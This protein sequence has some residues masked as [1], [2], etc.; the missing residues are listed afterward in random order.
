MFADLPGTDTVLF[1]GLDNR[2][3]GL[4]DTWRLNTAAEAWTRVRGPRPPR[5]IGGMAFDSA[6]GL[7][8]LYLGSTTTFE[9]IAQTWLFDPVTDSWEQASG[10]GA[11]AGL[12]G[13]SV[14]YDARS[15]RIVLFGGLDV[16]T[17]ELRDETWI[18]D[19]EADLW[20]VVETTPRPAGR[21]FAAT[22]YDTGSDA[23]ILFGGDTFEGPLDDTWSFDTDTQTWTEIT[24][25]PRPP[26]RAYS[27]AASVTDG[28]VVLFGGVNELPGQ[29]AVYGDTWILDTATQTWTEV[30]QSRSPGPRGF[31]AMTGDAGGGVVVMFGGGRTRE[32]VGDQTWTFD[33]TSRT[34]AR[35]C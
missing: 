32:R 9:P 26:A 20:S 30:T 31:H 21:N 18:Y 16:A 12:I 33:V 1:G 34:W 10:E 24:T 27:G 17:F 35:V 23:I 11:P 22:A 29:E 7:A 5:A 3:H 13:P 4:R 14:A 25:D 15:H 8:V 19:V 2:F 28:E 6:H